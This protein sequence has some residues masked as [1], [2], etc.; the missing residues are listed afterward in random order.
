VTPQKT[1]FQLRPEEKKV[2]SAE[3]GSIFN[4][5]DSNHSLFKICKKLRVKNILLNANAKII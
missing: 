2:L 1:Y 5:T 4:E 3:S